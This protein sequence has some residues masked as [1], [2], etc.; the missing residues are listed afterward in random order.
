MISARCWLK[1]AVCRTIGMIPSVRAR[2][3]SASIW[4]VGQAVRHA[5][6]LELRVDFFANPRAPCG[7]VFLQLARAERIVLQGRHEHLRGGGGAQEAVVDAPAGRGLHD[8]RRIA[9]GDDAIG[10]RPGDRCER[11]HLAPRVR[12][13]LA[14]HCHSPPLGD[15]GEKA[16]ERFGGVAIAHQADPRKRSG[17]PLDRHGPREAVRRDRAAEV[18]LHVTQLPHRQFRLGR[19]DEHGGHSEAQPALQR[20]VG[21]AGQDADAR[22]ANGAV[23][24][25]KTRASRVDGDVGH[26]LSH[27]DAGARANGPGRQHA[28]EYEPIDRER[29]DGRRGV[30][31]GAAGG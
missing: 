16:P 28:I 4:H 8:P 21:P 17:G 12:A 22:G 10:E 3:N 31:D 26:P 24:D 14:R 29:L 23:A 20:V 13:S 15:T 19:L 11:Q 1:R 2:S 9:D 5:A 25:R 27:H 18:H 6:E 7:F 30:L